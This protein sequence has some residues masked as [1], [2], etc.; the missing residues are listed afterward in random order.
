MVRRVWAQQ[1]RLYCQ[2]IWHAAD[3]SLSCLSQRPKRDAGSS[4]MSSIRP[5]A[6]PSRCAEVI[7]AFAQMVQTIVFRHKGRLERVMAEFN[8][9][10]IRR[11]RDRHTNRVLKIDFQF[12]SAMQT[13]PCDE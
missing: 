2:R 5:S 6:L 4:R 8:A 9:S 7:R 10:S 1:E 12:F 13:R 3:A 11:V